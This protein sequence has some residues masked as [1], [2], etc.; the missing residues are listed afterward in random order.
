MSTPPVAGIVPP[1]M[2]EQRSTPAEARTRQADRGPVGEDGM[3]VL[4]YVLSG[5]LLYG[6]LG[7]LG[8]RYLHAF[9]LLPLGLVVGLVASTYLII[10]R[11]GSQS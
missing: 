11:Y 9:W 8:S 1:T 7:W 3:L 2:D 10:K 5:I 6:G 4:S